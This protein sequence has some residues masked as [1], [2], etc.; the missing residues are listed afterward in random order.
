[1]AV[2]ES[3][4]GGR[5]KH[6]NVKHNFLRD[7]IKLSVI[8]PEWVA[9]AGQQADIMT[10]PLDRVTFARMCDLVMGVART[11]SEASSSSQ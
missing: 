5:R 1:M 3:N 4:T 2:D 8:K 6:I 11:S 7:Q 10:K 9:T